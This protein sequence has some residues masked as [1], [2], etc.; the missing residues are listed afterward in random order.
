MKLFATILAL[1]TT[2]AAAADYACSKQ[3]PGYGLRKFNKL[4][5]LKDDTER[6]IVQAKQFWYREHCDSF[7]RFWSRRALCLDIENIQYDQ[8][9]K[10]NQTNQKIQYY[11]QHCRKFIK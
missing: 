7:W 8:E 10:L 9:R 5:K 3:A 11:E 4:L 1:T 6:R 2:T